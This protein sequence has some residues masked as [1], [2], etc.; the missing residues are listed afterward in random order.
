MKKTN[1][2][3]TSKMYIDKRE[4]FIEMLISQYRGIPTNRLCKMIQLLTTRVA[5]KFY[6]D[7]YIDKQDSISDATI[8]ILE[9]IKNFDPERYDDAF[10]WLTEV[11]KRS[12][13]YSFKKRNKALMKGERIRI[14]DEMSRLM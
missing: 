1:I 2:T 5:T 3:K 12:F 10:P 6:F 14:T 11:T 7:D 9:N 13:A 4:L 8:R